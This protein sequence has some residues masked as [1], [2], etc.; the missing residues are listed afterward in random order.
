MS[1]RQTATFL[2]QRLRE[3]GLHPDPRHGQNFLIDLNL[4]ELLAR[5][6]DVG[7]N[8]VVLE[9]GTGT[10]ALTALLA[11]EAAQVVTIEIDRHL[12]QLAAEVLADFTN[13]TMLHQDALRNKNNFHAN[14]L[15][16]VRERIAAAPGRRLKL[17]ANLP[18]NI[19]TPVIS[20]LLLTDLDPVS[21]T[22]TIQ[23]E[24]ADRITARPGSK[25]YGALSVWIQSLCDAEVVRVMPPTVF[26]PKPKVHSAI[27]H[28]VPNAEKRERIAKVPFFHGFARAIFFHR[29]K[30]LRSELLSAFK[31]RLDKPQ[32]DEILVSLGL[33]RDTRAEQLP[34]ETMLALAEK[35]R[36][37]VGDERP[38]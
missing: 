36:E 37:K 7:S 12:F 38:A 3:A 22:V 8:D 35:I 33:G 21:L 6:A 10:G 26:W 1:P 9:V 5:T 19:A 27:V 11:A 15:D 23:K 17:V 32:A 28:I 20:N 25:D 16:T 13:V 30:F 31:G 14:V 18:Y 29:R 24:L 2:K 4:L 34:V